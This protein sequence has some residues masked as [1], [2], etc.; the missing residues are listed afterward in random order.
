MRRRTITREQ[1]QVVGKLPPWRQPDTSGA[2]NGIPTWHLR[3]FHKA[4]PK[5]TFTLPN[6]VYST[7]LLCFDLPTGVDGRVF[8]GKGMFSTLPSELN[9]S[10]THDSTHL[11]FRRMALIDEW[12]IPLDQQ[13]SSNL[14]QTQ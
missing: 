7:T 11:T 2:K 13:F 6:M 9:K 14:P 1:I 5:E 4:L 12:V 3:N 8:S 10:S